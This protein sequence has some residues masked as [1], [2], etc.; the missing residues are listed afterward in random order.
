MLPFSSVH[1]AIDKLIS[2]KC[3]SLCCQP[4][5]PT[6]PI[7]H[8][9]IYVIVAKLRCVSSLLRE[10]VCPSCSKPT[11]ASMQIC[12]AIAFFVEAFPPTPVN[13]SGQMS[14]RN[15]RDI[16]AARCARHRERNREHRR[17]RSPATMTASGGANEH[18]ICALFGY[19]PPFRLASRLNPRG[20]RSGKLPAP[21][22]SAN[23]EVN[24]RN[25]SMLGTRNK[26]MLNL[27]SFGRSPALSGCALC[28]PTGRFLRCALKYRTVCYIVGTSLPG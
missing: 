1:V 23:C 2:C 11:V 12:R 21:S 9:I 16:E 14:Q 28:K 3:P 17:H 5:L 25:H 8:A 7:D 13:Q 19:R 6:T 26:S 24:N 15:R 10:P 20:R 18:L 22:A 27:V 4:H